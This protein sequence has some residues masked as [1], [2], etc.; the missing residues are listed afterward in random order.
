MKELRAVSFVGM[1]LGVSLITLGYK[2]W[3]DSK[4]LAAEGKST[5]AQIKDH[6]DHESRGERKYYLTLAFETDKKQART[7]RARVSS[8][9]YQ[10]AVAAGTVQVHYLPR[11]P[12]LL[13]VGPNVRIRHNALIAGAFQLVFAVGGWLL[14]RKLRQS[15]SKSVDGSGE[16]QHDAREQPQPNEKAA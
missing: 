6:N 3:R 7:H 9:I 10:S 13:Q 5:I 2:H 11:K 12:E 16:S 4:Q 14:Y 8:Q 1:I 15:T